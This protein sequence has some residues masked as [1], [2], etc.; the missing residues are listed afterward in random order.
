MSIQ[1]S[2]LE[3]HLIIADITKITPEDSDTVTNVLHG[4]P[5]ITQGLGISHI[6]H[7]CVCHFQPVS[8]EF[9]FLCEFLI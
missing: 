1:P 7:Y 5:D 6:F 9:I 2:F 4:E 3:N 8:L